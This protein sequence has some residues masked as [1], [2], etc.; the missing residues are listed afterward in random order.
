MVHR[1][2]DNPLFYNKTYS[3]AT[4]SE[5]RRVLNETGLNVNQALI[6]KRKNT[7]NG[8]SDYQRARMLQHETMKSDVDAS[9]MD[10]YQRASVIRRRTNLT[11]FDEHG[12]NVYQQVS[13]KS[14]TTKTL[15]VDTAGLNGHQRAAAK[16]AGTRRDDVDSD[17]LNSYQRASRSEGKSYKI[18][19]HPKYGCFRNARALAEVLGVSKGTVLHLRRHN[20]EII[21]D[22]LSYNRNSFLQGYSSK[23]DLV[24]KTWKEIGF[25]LDD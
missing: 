1:A 11:S 13:I 22:V 15:D 2:I 7:E 17:N 18:M 24:G 10:G 9:G 23:E 12:L 19:C 25:Y 14:S 20:F 3:G 5:L 4:I 6:D 16:A 8:V 21:I